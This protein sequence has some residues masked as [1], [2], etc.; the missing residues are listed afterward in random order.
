MEYSNNCYLWQVDGIQ[1]NQ[2]LC[3]QFWNCPRDQ[4]RLNRKLL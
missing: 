2:L 1:V 3:F 4:T